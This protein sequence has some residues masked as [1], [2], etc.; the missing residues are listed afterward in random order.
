MKRKGQSSPLSTPPRHI[1]PIRPSSAPTQPTH[2]EKPRRRLA[3]VV[4][5]WGFFYATPSY[6]IYTGCP[7]H[8][9][10]ATAHQLLSVRCAT[11]RD[12]RTKRQHNTHCELYGGLIMLTSRTTAPPPSPIS[13]RL[14]WNIARAGNWLPLA[15]AL[16]FRRLSFGSGAS[17]SRRANCGIYIALERGTTAHY[18][19]R[20]RRSR[21]GDLHGALSTRRAIPG[22]IGKHSKPPPD[23]RRRAMHS[24]AGALV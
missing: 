24:I 12:T 1:R 7:S 9:S 3:I 4:D 2:G 19:L 16:L 6:C 17:T 13:E 21:R 22:G 18:A 10:L 20:S 11:P 14:R 23:I 5:D 15:C 8:L